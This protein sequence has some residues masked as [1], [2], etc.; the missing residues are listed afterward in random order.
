[1]LLF[2]TI[3][4]TAQPANKQELTVQQT[5]QNLITVLLNRDTA[6]LRLHSTADVHF[7][8]YRE[9][10]TIG[11]LIQNVMFVKPA[12]YKRTNSFDFTNT[13]IDGNSCMG[14]T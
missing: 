11:T 3:T 8:E 12:D 10:C 7:Y 9:V 2:V 13:T 1:M 14:K 6:G 5:I 4:A